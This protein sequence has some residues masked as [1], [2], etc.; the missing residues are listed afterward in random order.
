MMLAKGAACFLCRK[1]KSKC[2]GLK[3]L[4]SRCQR[5]GAIC[6]YAEGIKRRRRQPINEALEARA[7][8]L[9]LIIHKLA[10]TSAHSLSLASTKLLDRV[11]RLGGLGNPS[12]V[13]DPINPTQLPNSSAFRPAGKPGVSRSRGKLDLN[14][15]TKGDHFA[16]LED[17]A[18]QL[19]LFQLDQLQVLPASLS[20]EL[21]TLFLPHRLSFTFFMDLDQFFRRLS[22]PPSDPESI[23]PCLLNACYLGACGSNRGSLTA[24]QPYFVQRTRYF[25]QQSL[26][27]ADRTNHFLWASV[28]L[29]SFFTRERRLVEALTVVGATTCFAL[30]CGLNLPGDPFMQWENSSSYVSEYLLPPPKCSAE[31]DERIR[32][33]H[34][35]YIMG[36]AL[37]VLCGHP[38]IFNHDNRW[39]PMLEKVALKPH[40][41]KV[42]I[43]HVKMYWVMKKFVGL[44][45]R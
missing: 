26:M 20:L 22:L 43:Y 33:A 10:M 7:M 35:I 32:L 18:R 41:G 45:H 2:D 11:G 36:Q 14:I 34:S 39:A 19:G 31:A 8:E 15:T 21:V 1:H 12:Q 38:P 5:L 29:A 13:P 28:I 27:F 24:F 30:A 3:P 4:C 42:C 23:H 6:I 44:Y 9:E 40:D 17:L 25:L 16:V 37:P